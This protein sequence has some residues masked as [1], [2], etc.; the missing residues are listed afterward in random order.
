M[1]VLPVG[2]ALFAE[3]QFLRSPYRPG[4][5]YFPHPPQAYGGP[6]PYNQRFQRSLAEAS[7]TVMESI[8]QFKS[9]ND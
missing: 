1:G 2:S 3:E 5:G 6:Y 4:P 9:K 7:R 8:D